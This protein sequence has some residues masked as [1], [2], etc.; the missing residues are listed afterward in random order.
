[1][2]SPL[3]IIKLCHIQIYYDLYVQNCYITGPGHPTSRKLIHGNSVSTFLQT[4]KHSFVLFWFV[5]VCFGLF[6]FVLV[7]FG[8]VLSNTKMADQAR[9]EAPL[10]PFFFG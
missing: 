1:M 4:V 3:A 8:L 6:W 5:L 9:S 7:C 2:A 10:A